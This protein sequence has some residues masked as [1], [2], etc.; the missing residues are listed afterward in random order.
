[1]ADIR[2]NGVFI[3]GNERYTSI[4]YE[5][6]YGGYAPSYYYYYPEDDNMFK[7]YSAGRQYCLLLPIKE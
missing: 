1:M 5:N 3:K 6:A 4:T 2:K 7:K